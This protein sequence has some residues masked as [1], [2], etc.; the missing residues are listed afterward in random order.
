MPTDPH[1][2]LGSRLRRQVHRPRPQRR[3]RE[4][5]AG[6]RRCRAASSA[7]RTRCPHRLWRRRP[8][9]P[10]LLRSPQTVGHGG[11]GCTNADGAANSLGISTERR[12]HS[13]GRVQLRRR[14]QKDFRPSPPRPPPAPR[15]ELRPGSPRPLRE[16]RR[17]AMAAPRTSSDRRTNAPSF[18]RTAAL[19]PRSVISATTATTRALAA[20]TAVLARQATLPRLP[21]A[22]PASFCWRPVASRRAGPRPALRQ[23]CAQRKI[24]RA[25]LC[26][27]LLPSA[28]TLAWSPMAAGPSPTSE[29]CPVSPL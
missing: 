29:S 15:F 8:R 27:A 12:A 17:M 2:D 24:G 14:P 7:G 16:A 11:S 20:A 10:Q 23:P 28:G 3:L 18:S 1:L 6:G 9:P 22:R 13:G 25:K 4:R 21:A 19:R 26:G 5:H